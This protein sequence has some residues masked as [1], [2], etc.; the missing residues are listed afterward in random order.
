M[1]KEKWV[2]FYYLILVYRDKTVYDGE[3]VN[4]KAEGK[5]KISFPDQSMYE[6]YWCNGN[7]PKII[8][9]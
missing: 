9:N 3:F 6:G 5:G 4:G 8:R 1:E 7:Y 2:K